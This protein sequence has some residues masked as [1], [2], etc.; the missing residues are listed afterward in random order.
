M[1]D[2]T[3]NNGTVEAAT[4]SEAPSLQEGVETTSSA[5]PIVD[6]Y[7][8]RVDALLKHHEK[9]EEYK[10]Q[11]AKQ[12]EEQKVRTYENI[13]LDEGESFDAIYDTQPPEVQRLL[14]SLR[15]DYT[16]KMQALSKQRRELEDLQS[17]LTTS[18]AYKALQQA[19][20][21]ASAS[22]EEFDPFD[23]NSF[24]AYVD[25]QVT[26]KLQQV[27]QP[28]AEQQQQNAN[29]RKLNDFM[30][31]HPELKTDE[32]IRSAVRDMLVAN[33]SL[34]LQ[35][36]YWIVK[37]QQSKHLQQQQQKQEQQKKD[38]NRQVASR[39][40][41]GRK[42]GLTIPPNAHELKGV[43]IYEMLLAQKK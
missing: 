14:G 10:Q 22:G 38:I 36:A 21:E 24:Q 12:E 17:T 35:Q 43:D 11:N 4:Q 6:E 20:T 23:T 32:N 18:D 40:G 42:N 30:D 39:I 13:S 7:Q 3:T 19:A 28:L 26:Q 16:R 27:L 5:P 8:Q 15:G 2:E 9:T 31:Q 37:G 1:S 41:N 33:E 25:R 29:M 34:N